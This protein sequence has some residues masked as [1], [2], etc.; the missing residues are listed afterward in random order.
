MKRLLGALMLAGV[1]GGLFT[2]MAMESG[3]A[4]AAMTWAVAIGLAA[5][6]LVAVWLLSDG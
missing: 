5:V 4:A 1:F 3:F 6:V 2:A